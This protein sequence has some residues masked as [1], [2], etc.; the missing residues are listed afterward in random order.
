MPQIQPSKTKQALITHEGHT[1]E[2]YSVVFSPDGKSVASGS[3]D[4]TIRIWDA[5]HPSPIGGAFKGHTEIIR[6]IAYSPL[7]DV[8]T[9]GSWDRTVRLWDINTG[10]QMGGPLGEHDSI[11]Y[12]VAFSS[13]N[14]IASGSGNGTIQLWDAQ[15]RTPASGP[16]KGHASSVAS[17]AFS[18][19]GTRM[20]SGSYDKTLRIWDVEHGTII[21]GPL[22][23]HTEWVRSVAI[24]PDGSQVVSGSD[25]KT[26]RLWDARIGRTIGKPYEGHT[27][28]LMSVAFSPSGT[29]IA[30]GA[31]DW[32]IRFWDVRAGRQI[33]D[34]MKNHTGTVYSVAFS[35]SGDRIA[36]GSYDKTVKIWGISDSDSGVEHHHHAI[37]DVNMQRPKTPK[38]ENTDTIN[39]HMSAQELFQLLSRHSCTDLSLQMSPKQDT[40]VL[41]SGGGF[42]DIWRGEMHNGTKVA[43]KAWR[44]SMIGQCDYK[45]LKRAARE[46][47]TWSKMKHE[48]V[49]Q[50]MGV[51]MFKDRHL[52]MVSEWMENGNL[53]EYM[54]KNPQ[55]DR[56]NMVNLQLYSIQPGSGCRLSLHDSISV[57]KSHQA[58][59]TCTTMT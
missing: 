54:H 57:F 7:G 20:V 45:S 14:L 30:S 1:G 16:L 23:S 26:L 38:I 18:H 6:S 29:Y 41:I 25:D 32:T 2:A 42:G 33:E 31:S 15:S 27:N 55:L 39:Q 5:Y 35:P 34:L 3:D 58:S 37:F 36:S 13:G 40:A 28:W 24:S 52:G 46:I 10:R 56:Y 17:V 47:H 12:S 44:A 21:T 4:T 22:E 11:V 49:H 8:V 59:H 43:I 53:H 51:I 19:D 48:N 9:S 50:L